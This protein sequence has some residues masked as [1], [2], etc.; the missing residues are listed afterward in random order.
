MLEIDKPKWRGGRGGRRGEGEEGGLF[1]AF[2]HTPSLFSLCNPVDVSGN[3]NNSSTLVSTTRTLFT[4]MQR[5][6][7]DLL[8]SL[9]QMK[10]TRKSIKMNL[11]KI[12]RY[13]THK[14]KGTPFGE[15]FNHLNP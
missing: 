8:H 13:E 12:L 5:K 11:M 7:G 3:K 9:K 10:Q 1:Y 6:K 14:Q 15:W 4:Q 2:M